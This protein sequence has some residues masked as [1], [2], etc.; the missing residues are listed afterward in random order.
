MAQAPDILDA[1]LELPEPAHRAGRGREG[2]PAHQDALARGL[3]LVRDGASYRR[4]AAAVG[5]D[6]MT[7]WRYVRRSET[8]QDDRY[9][10]IAAKAAQGTERAVDR[11][12]EGIQTCDERVVAQWASTLA[13]IAGIGADAH[14]GLGA[15]GDALGI[16]GATGGTIEVGTVAR[17]TV[18]PSR[19][20]TE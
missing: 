2:D 11:M 1:E 20:P 7:L 5:V 15:A 10:L 19:L 6:D 3:A 18:N 14:A 4:A 8:A 12:A 9:A 13:R 16:L 17:V